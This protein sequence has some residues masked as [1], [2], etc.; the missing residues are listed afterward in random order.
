MNYMSQGAV[1]SFF[2]SG[3]DERD[4]ADRLSES[5]TGFWP[6]DGRREKREGEE[7]RD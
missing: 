1:H 3:A 7:R 2:A 6:L 5:L 4:S